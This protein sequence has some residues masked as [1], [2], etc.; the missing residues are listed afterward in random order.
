MEPGPG[1]LERG[2]SLMEPGPGGLGRGPS[3]V[4]PGPVGLGRGSQRLR[5]LSP[6]VRAEA[7]GV[8][9]PRVPIEPHM[10]KG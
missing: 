1:G 3:L 2:P 6:S 4:E 10:T 8:A 7:D 9:E 5:D